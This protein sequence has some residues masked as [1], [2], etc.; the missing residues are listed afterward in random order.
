M[1]NTSIKPYITGFNKFILII[2]IINL[3]TYTLTNIQ[4]KKQ[5]IELENL[6]L[7]IIQIEIS[8]LKLYYEIITKKEYKKNFF[9][10]AN[11]YELNTV[12]Y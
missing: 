4:E 10:F 2:I 9:F 11:F 7:I 6:R 8:W 5:C 1:F 12:N 3:L